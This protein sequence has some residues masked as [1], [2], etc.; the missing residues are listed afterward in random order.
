MNPAV[1]RIF[2]EIEILRVEMLKE[3]GVLSPDRFDRRQN[4][5]WSVAQ[6]L[7]HLLTSERLSLHYMKKKSLGIH[8]AEEAGWLESLKL[9]A[10]KISQRLP[11][12][13]N[14]PAVVIK[15]TPEALEFAEL[16]RQWE[17]ERNELRLFLENMPDKYINKKIYKHPVA[18]RLN[19]KQALAFFREHLKHHRPQII[20]QL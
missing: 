1:K 8:A 18:G 13:Y 4:D 7:T 14:A 20:R 16:A 6:I 5:K 10:L 17:N 15:E 11:F 3:T 19:V 9:V 2:D 12:K